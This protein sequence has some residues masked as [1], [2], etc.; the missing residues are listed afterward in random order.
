VIDFQGNERRRSGFVVNGTSG[1]VAGSR[2]GGRLGEYFGTAE[3]KRK[4]HWPKGQVVA[5]LFSGRS[6]VAAVVF[7]RLH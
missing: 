3:R 7:N 5:S 1:L 2:N 4:V 6:C